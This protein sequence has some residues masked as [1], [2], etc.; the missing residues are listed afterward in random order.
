[1]QVQSIS[2]ELTQ[3]TNIQCTGNQ[4]LVGFYSG[5]T[6]GQTEGSKHDMV[7]AEVF[8]LSL[9]C[10]KSAE[11]IK[12]VRAQTGGTFKNVQRI[13]RA[14]LCEVIAMA[15]SELVFKQLPASLPTG[16]SNVQSRRSGLKPTPRKCHNSGTTRQPNL[17][18]TSQSRHPLEGK[19][20]SMRIVYCFKL[21]KQHLLARYLLGTSRCT[22]KVY[23]RRPPHDHSIGALNLWLSI[24]W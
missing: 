4:S 15:N 7:G 21:I 20:M 24:N 11:L 19:A 8:F 3:R 10:L 17:P 22:R 13:T 6:S 23:Q 18:D 5:Q 9:L 16:I 12:I 1:M 2:T 14:R